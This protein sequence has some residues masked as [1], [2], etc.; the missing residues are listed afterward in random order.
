MTI[1]HVKSKEDLHTTSA[2][3]FHTL[4][5]KDYQEGTSDNYFPDGVY[6]KGVLDTNLRVIVSTEDDIG[7]EDYQFWVVLR[8]SSGT[9]VQTE[10][11]A[12]EYIIKKLL[13]ANYSVCRSIENGN[14]NQIKRLVYRLRD[15]GYIEGV[16]EMVTIK[17]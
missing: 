10:E 2:K 17:D 14:N 7:Y 1:L 15:D 13:Y 3:I 6:F 5:I 9:S 12:V 11:A 16:P 4:G 8:T